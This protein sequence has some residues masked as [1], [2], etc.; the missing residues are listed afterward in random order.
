MRPGHKF[1]ILS[2][3]LL[4]A[5]VGFMSCSDEGSLEQKTTACESTVDSVL[6][7]DSVM[8]VYEV[9]GDADRSL[10]LVHC[11]CCDRGY[12]ANQI[13][14]FSKKYRVV[15]VDLA[16]HGESGDE[17]TEWSMESFGDDVAAVVNKLDLKDVILVGHSMGGRINLEAARK[18]PNRVKALIGIDN[19][20]N[21]EQKFTPEQLD[22]FLMPFRALFQ[23]TAD[24]YVRSL[25]SPTADS[26]LVEK[27]ATDMASAPEEIGVST[28][29][30]IW[31]HD[32]IAALEE[33]RLPIR[34]IVSDVYS[35]NME[36]NS[37]VAAS[38][39]ATV[40]PDVGH[41]IQMEKPDEF[42][43]VLSKTILEFWPEGQE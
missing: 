38:F 12:F 8:I 34:A 39:K 40:I 5:T 27:T 11:W 25:F 9:Y 35:V 21:F 36:G 3:I 14:Y 10:V 22:Q 4:S 37:Q 19:Y 42:N 23:M 31:S 30:A 18:L 33:M 26:A 2:L 28:M 20:H 43:R 1:F 16:G 7:A 17:R 6:S 32:A 41:F 15:T 13:D 29:A 24:Q